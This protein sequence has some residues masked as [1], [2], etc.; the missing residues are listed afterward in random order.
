MTGPYSQTVENPETGE[1]QRRLGTNLVERL[2]LAPFSHNH[3][4]LHVSQ[5][6]ARADQQ[7][8]QASYH[9]RHDYGTFLP[10]SLLVLKEEAS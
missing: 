2:G 10:L 3:I 7:A 6:L 5:S 4:L 8:H 9:L 1:F